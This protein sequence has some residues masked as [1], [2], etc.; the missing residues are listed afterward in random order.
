M[1]P[2]FSIIIP[3]LNEEKYLPR[4]LESLSKQLLKD[5]EVIIVDGGS[6]D[7]TIEIAMA[8]ADKVV[9]ERCNQSKARNI[10]ASISSGKYL[11][12]LDADAAVDPL[13]LEKARDMFIEYERINTKCIVGRPEPITLTKVGRAAFAFGWLLCRFKATF[14]GY[15]GILV[16]RSIFKRA[17]GFNPNLAYGEDL[18][19]LIRVSAITKIAYPKDLVVYSDTRRW[20]RNGK[21]NIIEVSRIVGMV[22]EYL[23]TRRSHSSYPVIR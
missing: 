21:I 15:M 19:F 23:T 13:F 5:F 2:Y 3:T 14:P 12:F 6:S 17:G 7:K 18:D 1:N 20:M 16:E 9:I 22:V 11:V 8:H 4:L 10:G